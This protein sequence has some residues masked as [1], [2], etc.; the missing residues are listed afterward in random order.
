M[1]L[2]ALFEEFCHYL[3]VEKEAA[4][5]SIDTYQWCFGDFIEFAQKKVGGTVL[6]SHFTPEMCRAYQYDLSARELKTNTIRVRLA[7]LGSFGKW[8][9]YR[10]RIDKNPMDRLTRPRRRRRLPRVPRFAKVQQFIENSADRRQKALLALMLYG[11]LRRSE[12]VS[13][14]VDDFITDFGLR[15][16]KGKGGKED[17]VPLPEAARCII[18]E[19]LSHDRRTARAGDPMFVVRYRTR[20]GEWCERRMADH[21]VWKIIKALGRREGVIQLHPHAFRHSSAVE[22]LRRSRNLRAVQ[23]HLRHS[24]IQTTTVYTEI[25]QSEL[26]KVVNLFDEDGK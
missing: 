26:Q 20:G 19:Y 5:R 24:D 13:L 6:I 7:T 4:P 18:A 11:A 22:L 21:R 25:T 23:A 15:R 10:E 9:V 2:S 17:A 8:A 3:R 16:V 1:R 14:N 12:V